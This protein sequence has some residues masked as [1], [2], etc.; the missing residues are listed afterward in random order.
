MTKGSCA[1]AKGVGFRRTIHTHVVRPRPLPRPDQAR[2]ASTRVWL[3]TLSSLI[4]D[5]VSECGLYI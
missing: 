5:L 2:R 1:P 3:S 4:H